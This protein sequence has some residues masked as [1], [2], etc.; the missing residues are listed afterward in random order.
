[1]VNER[2]LVIVGLHQDGSYTIGWLKTPS[3]RVLVPWTEDVP[4]LSQGFLVGQII[5][6]G[7]EIY[8]IRF[9]SKRCFFRNVVRPQRPLGLRDTH[10]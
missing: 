1:M 10:N 9:F 5:D 8:V 6:F 7:S 2:F 4:R 3:L